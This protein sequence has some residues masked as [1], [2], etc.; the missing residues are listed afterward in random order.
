MEPH[1]GESS[2]CSSFT[3][4]PKEGCEGSALHRDWHCR[5]GKMDCSVH[6]GTS[7]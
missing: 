6:V 7:G 2:G 5:R 3:N 1:S 4:W